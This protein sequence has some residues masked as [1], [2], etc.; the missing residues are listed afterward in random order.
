MVPP[1]CCGRENEEEVVTEMGAEDRGLQKDFNLGMEKDF[2]RRRSSSFERG[3]ETS[4]TL[5]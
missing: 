3:K 5:S 1:L 4:R 2:S